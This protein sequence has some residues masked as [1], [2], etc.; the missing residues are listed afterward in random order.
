MEKNRKMVPYFQVATTSIEQ[1]VWLYTSSKRQDQAALRDLNI[2]TMKKIAQEKG[3]VV[4]GISTDS[5][6]QLPPIERPG[7]HHL[8]REMGTFL[9]IISE[10]YKLKVQIHTKDDYVHSLPLLL[11]YPQKKKGGDAR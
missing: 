5:N 4:A 6:R 11:K 1:K 2:E 7:L 9:P 3:L 10:L 8:S